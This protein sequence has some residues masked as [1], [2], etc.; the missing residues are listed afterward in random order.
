M[1]RYLSC[2]RC[3]NVSRRR[4]LARLIAVRFANMA[5]RY[6]VVLCRGMSEKNDSQEIYAETLKTAGYTCN[7]LPTLTFKFVN[8]SE[9]RTC[10]RAPD[11]YHGLI[12]TSKR[13]V[14]AIDLVS[15]E[16]QQIL[17]PWKMLPVYCVGP[18]TESFAK[19]HLGSENC[20]GRDTGN[21]KELAEL[22]VKSVS[23]GLKPL[24]YPCSEIG[25][26]T[27]EKTLTEHN[28][29]VTKIVVYRTLPCETLE[30]DLSA[31]MDH[32]PRIFVFFSP[33]TVEFIVTI[34][35]KKSYDSSNIKAVAIGPVTKHALLNADLEVFAT[36]DKP[37]SSSLLEAIVNAERSE[38]A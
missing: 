12:L 34:L 11:S 14:E 20:F 37:D 23:E 24:L 25:R 15:K 38:I 5:S 31:F 22:L 27:I 7:C 29:P 2:Y 26:D 3:S 10:L 36:A 16:N 4:F 17:L 13:A 33:S 35:K 18:T 9:L 6:G 32:V 30:N 1:T 8:T 19:S 28:I 21:A